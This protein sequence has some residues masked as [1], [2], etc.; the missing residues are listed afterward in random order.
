MSTQSS[1]VASS[2]SK[3]FDLSSAAL[4]PEGSDLPMEMPAL[5]GRGLRS[6]L[7]MFSMLRVILF[8]AQHAVLNTFLGIQAVDRKS[9]PWDRGTY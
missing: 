9:A 3:R 2:R 7:V 5:S 8:G 1:K 6:V 4:E